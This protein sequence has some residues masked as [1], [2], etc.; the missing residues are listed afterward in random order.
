VIDG[1]PIAGAVREVLLQ[2]RPMLRAT[3]KALNEGS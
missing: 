3:W 1:E 2:H